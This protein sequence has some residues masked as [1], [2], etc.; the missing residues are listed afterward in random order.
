MSVTVMLALMLTLLL[1]GNIPVAFAFGISSALYILTND[2]PV[3]III[4]RTFYGIHDFTL[5]AIPLFILAGNVMNVSGVSSRIFQF[6]NALVGHTKG[7]LANVC[8][9]AS[10][11]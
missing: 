5:L 1:I 4:Q 11:L 8:V 9:V 2:V 6:A 10:M 7:G 3:A